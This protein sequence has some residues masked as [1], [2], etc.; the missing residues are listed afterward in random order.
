[1]MMIVVNKEESFK[2][3]Y[4]I[5]KQN[6]DSNVE[7]DR[8]FQHETK[9]DINSNIQICLFVNDQKKHFEFICFIRII[10]HRQ[11]FEICFQ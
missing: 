10:I 6:Y 3:A 5:F 8:L 1:M 2:C 11:H 4:K 9:S 7:F